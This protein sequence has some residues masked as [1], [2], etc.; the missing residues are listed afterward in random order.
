MAWLHP[1]VPTYGTGRM[2]RKGRISHR[3]WLRKYYPRIDGK[4]KEA[5]MKPLVDD[6]TIRLIR[7]LRVDGGTY[8]HISDVTGQ[9]LH[10]IGHICKGRKGINV[11]CRT[12]G[13]PLG[14]TFRDSHSAYCEWASLMWC[15]DTSCQIE[16]HR[17]Y[18]R[19]KMAV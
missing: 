2:L 1:T 8:Q 11:L 10:R 5:N 7:Q 9:P 3:L 6:K 4:R 15:E 13:L 17:E 19:T 14:Y 12:C 18:A 16:S